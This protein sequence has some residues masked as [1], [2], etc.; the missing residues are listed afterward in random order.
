VDCVLLIV[1]AIG[2]TA[3]S[4]MQFLRLD[5]DAIA[6]DWDLWF[7]AD[8]PRIILTSSDRTSVEQ[9]RNSVHPLWA[10]LVSFPQIILS[11]MGLDEK[12]LAMLLIS[13]GT[14]VLVA[15]FYAAV[16]LSGSR[17]PETVAAVLLFVST[18]ATMAW[19]IVPET[20]T[21][22]A[23][24]LLIPFVWLAVPR[25]RHDAWSGPLQSAISLSITL[26]NWFAGIT[27]AVI[28]SGWRRAVR[29]TVYAFASVAALA[30]LQS[31]IFPNA[32]K[33][34]GIGGEG[35]FFSPE[36]TERPIA[37]LGSLLVQPVLMPAPALLGDEE[38]M[39][40]AFA[41]VLPDW[42]A[43]S[44]LAATGWVVLLIAG[45]TM[46]WGPHRRLKVF[47]LIAL[48]F[49]YL[50]HSVYGDV[51]F[52][53]SLHFAPFLVLVATGA[54]HR[55]WRWRWPVLALMA[56]TAGAT[57][58]SNAPELATAISLTWAA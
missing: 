42:D 56:V 27:A 36:I 8:I 28:A 22:G 48:G 35:G 44:I 17:R 3:I 50:L 18:A 29:F 52:L 7:G 4:T 51:T 23:V 24:S 33:F 38:K 46:S 32:G 19:T 53:Y 25:G 13:A 58:V 12:Q 11:N 47:V 31:W 21:L 14:F 40:I 5:F 55:R 2:A 10:L 26:T 6:T 30:V 37:R 34:I 1:L 16:R 43:W 41:D 15:V 49:Q 20:Y 57:L 54:T 45:L 39:G 9:Q